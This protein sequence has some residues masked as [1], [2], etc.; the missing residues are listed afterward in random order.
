VKAWLVNA[1]TGSTVDLQVG[2]VLQNPFQTS[3]GESD[4][5]FLGTMQPGESKT[6][7]LTVDVDS[8]ATSQ[9][10]N[11]D[12]RLDWT[13]SDNSLDDILPVELQVTAAELPIPLIAAALVERR[14]ALGFE[15][16]NQGACRSKN[17]LKW[18][19]F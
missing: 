4:V 8:K 7:Y 1:G 17:T 6:A 3:S 19:G 2:L 9:T 15:K 11:T 14:E 18:K 16:A 13:Q 12:L 10:Y 5:F